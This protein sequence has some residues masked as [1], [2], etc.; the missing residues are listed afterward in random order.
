MCPNCQAI[1]LLWPIGN[2]MGCPRVRRVG[3]HNLL[4]TG[5]LLIEIL[6]LAC[7]PNALAFPMSSRWPTAARS[8]SPH[9]GPHHVLQWLDWARFGPSGEKWAVPRECRVGQYNFQPAGSLL[10]ETIVL[11]CDVNAPMF[12]MSPCWPTATRNLCLTSPHMGPLSCAPIVRQLA[13]F[14]PSGTQ[15]AAPRV[16]RVG[17]HNLLL[18]GFLPI[19]ILGL[20]CDPN[21][22]AFPMSSRWP[23][24]ARSGSPRM[25]PYRS[26]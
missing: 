8:S 25:G 17:L 19:E 6:V 7:D 20:A 18:T 14:G 24:A 10:I 1:G 9:M 26:L 5:F 15:W 21:T 11:A 23:T 16:R 2:A 22:L 4:L 13:R 3:L 12:P